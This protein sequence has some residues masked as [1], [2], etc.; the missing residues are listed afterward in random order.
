MWPILQFFQKKVISET[1]RARAKRTKIWDHKGYN[2]L[3]HHGQFCHFSKKKFA[4][5]EPSVLQIV[6]LSNINVRAPYFENLIMWPNWP[7]FAIFSRKK[8]VISETVRDRAKRTK[9]SDH[10]QIITKKEC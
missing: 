10:W 9:I 3:E 2:M 1:V 5:V 7:I 6:F 4:Y 8:V